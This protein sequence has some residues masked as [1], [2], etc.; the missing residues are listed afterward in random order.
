M[1]GTIKDRLKKKKLVYLRTT[2]SGTGI[3]SHP[4][5]AVEIDANYPWAGGFSH[6]R[7]DATA[8]TPKLARLINSRLKKAGMSTMEAD[9]APKDHDGAIWYSAHEISKE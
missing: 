4:I 8:F 6:R 3:K 7:E 2:R 5:W 9:P 1:T